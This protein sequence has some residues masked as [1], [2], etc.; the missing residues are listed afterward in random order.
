MVTD[1]GLTDRVE[2]DS[3][4]LIGFHAGE[5]PDSRSCAAAVRRGYRMDGLRSRPIDRHDFDHFDLILAMDGGHLRDL[6]K[7]APPDRR[8]R[9]RLFLDLV[10]E[11]AGRD[12]PDP[13]YGDMRDFERVLD[14]VERGARHLIQAIAC[15]QCE[16]LTNRAARAKS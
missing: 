14:L 1:A 15:D 3:A 11:L 5:A 9:I 2:I 7:M 13:Y 8:D 16:V 12:V 6:I 4:G 10:P